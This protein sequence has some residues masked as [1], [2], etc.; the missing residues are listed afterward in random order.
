MNY[1]LNNE[2]L[3]KSISLEI[4]ESDS[5]SDFLSLNKFFSSSHWHENIVVSRQFVDV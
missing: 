3:K 2:I 4:F 1:V 5:Q